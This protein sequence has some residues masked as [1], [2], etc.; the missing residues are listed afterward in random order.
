MEYIEKGYNILD[1]RV[2][3]SDSYCSAMIRELAKNDDNFVILED[4]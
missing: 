3:Y 1:K 2:S 4:E